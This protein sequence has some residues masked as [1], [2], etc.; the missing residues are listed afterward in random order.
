MGAHAYANVF[1]F[2]VISHTTHY[3]YII[4]GA[5]AAH[6]MVD[7][8]IVDRPIQLCVVSV[9]AANRMNMYP[10]LTAPF[11]QLPH[12]TAGHTFWGSAWLSNS[13]V[14]S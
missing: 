10:N 12:F 13:L 14:H 6:T 8:S 11:K 7:Y 2:S 5:N 1:I 9:P 4:P 3:T